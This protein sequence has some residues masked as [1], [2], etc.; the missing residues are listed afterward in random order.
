MLQIMTL[1][2]LSTKANTLR[3]PDYT[4]PSSSSSSI[5]I[6]W[7]PQIQRVAPQPPLTFQKPPEWHVQ[8]QL[9]GIF[10]TEVVF[11][12]ANKEAWGHPAGLFESP[13]RTAV[14]ILL[15]AADSV[16]LAKWPSSIGRP[17]V[18]NRGDRWLFRYSPHF[19]ILHNADT[20][21]WSSAWS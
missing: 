1:L 13:W 4:I 12:M 5:I 20:S 11:H 6:V 2:G 14:R 15:P 18:N 3:M 17:F 21:V 9:G 7:F 10:Q 8:Y 16:I 19:M